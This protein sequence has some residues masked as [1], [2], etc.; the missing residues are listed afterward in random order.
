MNSAI[1][2]IL[3][4]LVIDLDWV[5]K[6][7]GLIQ[8]LRR[9]GLKG[10]TGVFPVA[11]NVSPDYDPQVLTDMVPDSTKMS[12]VYFEDQGI[13]TRREGR[14]I[15]CTSRLRLVGW[16]NGKK[17]RYNSTQ[18][19]KS[20]NQVLLSLPNNYNSGDF[21]QIKIDSIVEETK[22]A[23]IFSQYSYSEEQTQ[24]LLYPNDY[25]S[26]IVTVNFRCSIDCFTDIDMVLLDDCGNDV[27]FDYCSHFEGSL[28]DRQ[29]DCITIT[30]IDGNTFVEN[31]EY[32]V[33][34]ATVT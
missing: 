25:F 22:S 11:T 4:S 32:G 7:S 24:Y 2:D 20:I 16:L 5:D 3:K 30:L 33:L 14:F 6:A 27:D 17:I 8:V 18:A 1:A 15:N 34:N 9:G 28:S 23:A 19:I 13:T 21:G 12:V 26:L 31:S 29:K 10:K